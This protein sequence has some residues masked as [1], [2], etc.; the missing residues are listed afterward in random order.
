MHYE[1]LGDPIFRERDVPRML[2]LGKARADGDTSV[3]EELRQYPAR[4]RS[5]R[6]SRTLTN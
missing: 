5:G 2:T 6:Q 3:P 4:S 1:I